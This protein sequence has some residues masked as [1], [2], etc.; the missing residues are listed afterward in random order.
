MGLL[1]RELQ[2]NTVRAWALAAILAFAVGAALGVAR[3]LVS[4]RLEALAPT[5]ATGLDD[6]AAELV[7]AARRW[8]LTTTAV[9]V[10]AFALALPPTVRA[11]LHAA[12]VVAL[13]AQGGLWGQAVIRHAL[14]VHIARS[15]DDGATK[16][17]SAFAAFAA[18]L[19]LWTLLLL[20]VLDNLGVNITA[21]LTGLGVGGWPWRSRCRTCW[22][23]FWARSRSRST[24]PSWWATS[25]WSTTSRAPW[26]TSG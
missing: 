15:G 13:A 20:V 18:Q 19:V 21:L 10:G 22:A 25:S 12:F 11:V 23:T 26:S 24:G 5:T 17:T 6:L 16:T 8:F 2:G 3:R 9:Y 1:D 14:A 4:R 7:A